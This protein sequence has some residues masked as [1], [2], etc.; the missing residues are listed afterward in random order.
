MTLVGSSLSARA[1][2]ARSMIIRALRDRPPEPEGIG[3]IRGVVAGL[4]VLLIV[5]WASHV[6]LS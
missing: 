1:R 4:I 3:I 2:G 6:W 5:M